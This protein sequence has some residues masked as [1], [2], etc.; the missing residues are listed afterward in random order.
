MKRIMFDTSVYGELVDEEEVLIRVNREAENHEFIIYGAQAI[1]KEL[2]ATPKS[3]THKSNK[4]R[5]LLLNIYDGFVSND[6]Q[7]LKFNKLVEDLSNDYFLEYKKNKGN[8]SNEDM[9]IDFIIIA[10]AT[11][12]QLDIIISDDENT[13]LSD[14]SIKSYE[15]VNRK[16]GLH[17]PIFKKYSQFKQELMR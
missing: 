16:Y 3:R 15:S 4:L 12:Y 13:M 1:R 5:I 9:L 6:N 11:I 2:R 10:T 7:N 14:K 8:L 17:D